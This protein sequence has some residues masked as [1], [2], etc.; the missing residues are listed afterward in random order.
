MLSNDK[1]RFRSFV[2]EIQEDTL[3]MLLGEP[4]RGVHEIGHRSET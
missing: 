3:S 4:R 2:R 1:Y